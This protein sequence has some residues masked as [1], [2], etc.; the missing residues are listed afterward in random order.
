MGVLTVKKGV[1]DVFDDPNY[2]KLF[3]RRSLVARR[4]ER[5][6]LA[7]R[8]A[9]FLGNFGYRDAAERRKLRHGFWSTLWLV[10]S[11]IT[12]AVRHSLVDTS[13]IKRA[14]DHLEARSSASAREA[15]KAVREAVAT[16]WGVWRK[17]A[18]RDREL[19]TPNNFF[20]SKLGIRSVK[21]GAASKTAAKLRSLG[22]FINSHR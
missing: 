21:R 15:R 9:T 16:V 10:H 20:K 14:F 1:D 3:P 19:W 6:Y 17:A 22:R 4:F 11:G 18:S 2:K 7:Y 12:T 5:I 8:I 13:S